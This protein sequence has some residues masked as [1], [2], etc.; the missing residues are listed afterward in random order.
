MRKALC[1][2]I[3]LTLAE[4]TELKQCNERLTAEVA[5]RER[6]IEQL[7]RENEKKQ[8]ELLAEL[9]YVKRQMEA[10]KRK[11]FGAP[12]SERISDDAVAVGDRSTRAGNRRTRDGG[13]GGYR[14]HPAPAQRRWGRGASARATRDDHRGN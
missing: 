6:R 13:Q 8:R 14:L 12:R 5:M 1:I 3:V 11:L 4:Q 9:A 2:H 10:L 7:A